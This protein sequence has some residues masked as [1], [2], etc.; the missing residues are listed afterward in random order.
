MKKLLLL[1]TLILT[2]CGLPIGNIDAKILDKAKTNCFMNGG[3]ESL[4]LTSDAP[5]KR[6]DAV[7]KNGAKFYVGA[8]Q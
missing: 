2:G 6:I 5:F 3:L 1:S 7:C 8:V 4:R